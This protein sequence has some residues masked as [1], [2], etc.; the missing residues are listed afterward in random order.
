[1]L[2]HEIAKLSVEERRALIDDLWDS[3][4]TEQALPPLSDEL[5]H[6]LDARYRESVENPDQKSYTLEEIAGRH[7]V[8]L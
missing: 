2:L 3:I 6:L 7:G 1:M 5:A 8:K 4:E